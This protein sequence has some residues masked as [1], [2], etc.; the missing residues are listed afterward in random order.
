MYNREIFQ[1]DSLSPLVFITYL[2]PLLM[3]PREAVHGCRFQQER[4]VNPLLCMHNLY[5]YGERKDY[6]EALINTV[7][8]FTDDKTMT[9][10][11]SKCATI[12]RREEGR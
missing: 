1:D 10:G 5:L 9:F 3:T 2:I 4:K 12:V 11:I 8:I 6:L 7:K